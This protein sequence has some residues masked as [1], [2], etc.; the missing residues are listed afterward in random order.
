MDKISINNLF[1][2]TN[3][4]QPLDVNTLC[5]PQE[6]KIKNKINFN[7]DRLIKLREERKQKIFIQ[8]DKIFN[9]CLNKIN[10]ANNLN[11]TET[12]YEVPEVIYG[13]FDY[14]SFACLHYIEDK[15]RNMNMDTILYNE[16][17]IYISWLNLEENIKNS[18]EKNNNDNRN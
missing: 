11:K 15:L 13:Y 10:L 12:M 4:F 3:D 1:P 7:I 9:M 8:Y 18:K 16:K 17:T 6:N 14:N 5:N 2:S